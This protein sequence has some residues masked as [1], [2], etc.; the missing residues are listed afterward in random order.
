MR[1][2]AQ[3][4]GITVE[5]TFGAVGAMQ[6]KVI[7]GEQS[8][9]VILRRDQIDLLAAKGLVLRDSIMDLGVVPTL[10]RRARFRSGSIHH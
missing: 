9:L 3:T 10:D 6:E 4:A 7:A 5:G 2:T 8:D 1:S